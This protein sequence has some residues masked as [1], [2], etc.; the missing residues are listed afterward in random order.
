MFALI[1]CNNFYVSCERAFDP[2]LEGKPVVVLSSNDGCI[3]AR[4]NEAKALGLKMGEP[5]F[6]RKDLVRR[7]KIITLSS[8]FTLYGDMSNRVMTL[9]K[10]FSPDF[11][12]YSID[13]MFLNLSGFELSRLKSYGKT[14]RQTILQGIGLPVSVGIGPTK[15]LCKAANYFSKQQNNLDGVCVLHDPTIIDFS[16]KCLPIEEVWGVGRKWSAK[17]KQM[18]LDTAH[19]L[20]KTDKSYIKKYFNVILTRTA[21]ELE[22]IACLDLEDVSARQNIMVSRSFGAKISALYDLEQA[23]SHF[24]MRACEKLRSQSSVA[25]SVVVFIRT[26]PFDEKN[27]QYSNSISLKF[28]KETDNSLLIVKTALSGLRKIYREDFLY[29]KAGVILLDTLPKEVRQNDLFISHEKM[30]NEPLMNVLDAVNERY[31][32][33]VLRLAICGYTPTWRSKRNNVSP[34][35]TTKWEDILIVRAN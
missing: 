1:D 35:Y 19:D 22:G 30:D 8:N 14:I 6:K 34:S 32:K 27:E 25:C 16:L 4:S 28:P 23:V 5:I 24:T 17:L 18:G 29:K 20:M 21:M 7:H 33:Q 15:T 11:E 2:R 12:I 26:S 13:E 10:N 9:L 31:G 3:I